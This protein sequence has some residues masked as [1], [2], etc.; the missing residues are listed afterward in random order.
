LINRANSNSRRIPNKSNRRQWPTALSALGVRAIVTN[1]FLALPTAAASLNLHFR[2]AAASRRWLWPM[3]PFKRQ[4]PPVARSVMEIKA[5]VAN[6]SSKELKNITRSL[7]EIG[8]NEVVEAT[9]GKQA[10]ELL[11]KG[12]YNFIVT[13]FNNETTQWNDLVSAARKF[14][15][16][17]PIIVTAPKSKKVEELKKECPTASKYLTMPFNTE[18]L[19]KTVSEY[20]PSLAC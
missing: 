18:Q 11:Q 9:S 19:K 3:H 12:K 20:A 1:R 14:D 5:L 15:G 2:G 10:M 8:V 13:E 17:L 4:R 16:K 7:K 6:S